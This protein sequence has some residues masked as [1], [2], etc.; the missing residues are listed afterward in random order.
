VA[1]PE[2]IERCLVNSGVVHESEDGRCDGSTASGHVA[3]RDQGAVDEAAD[4]CTVV[5]QRNMSRSC[6]VNCERDAEV[7]AR[8]RATAAAGPDEICLMVRGIAE[9]EAEAGNW[10]LVGWVVG[11]PAEHPQCSVTPRVA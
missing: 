6:V 11:R 3:S 7:V 4:R 1:D 2:L 8:D 5:G 9:A 10:V